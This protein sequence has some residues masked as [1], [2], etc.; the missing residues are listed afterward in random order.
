MVDPTP[1]GE[2]LEQIATRHGRAYNT[3]RT[4]WS[5]HP[6]WPAPIGKTGQTL[7]YDPTAVDRVIAKHFTRATPHFQPDRLYTAKEIEAATGIKAAT[8][9]ADVTKNRW[10]TPDDPTSRAKRWYGSTITHALSNR[11]T[12]RSSGT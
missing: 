7:L 9:R 11:R 3:L 10:P 1:T 12:Y 2:T 5:R 8:I 6:D 4:E